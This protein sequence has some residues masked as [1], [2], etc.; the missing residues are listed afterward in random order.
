MADDFKKLEVWKLA[1]E[2]AKDV[3]ISCKHFPKDEIYG[4]LSQVRRSAIS[5]PS[6]L[7]IFQPAHLQ[8]WKRS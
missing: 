4:M 8:S 2:L 1:M 6:N 3:Y 5:V 7:S